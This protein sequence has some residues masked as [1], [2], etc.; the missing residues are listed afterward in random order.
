MRTALGQI[1]AAH[2][3]MYNRETVVLDIT[4]PGPRGVKGG[5]LS[6]AGLKRV[7]RKHQGSV[8]AMINEVICRLLGKSS[9]MKTAAELS[10]PSGKEEVLVWAE[11]PAFRHHRM[12]AK[13]AKPT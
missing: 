6:Q 13:A 9:R 10:E 2:M 1:E 8:D 3:L 5:Q 4:N 11:V 12:S 7:D